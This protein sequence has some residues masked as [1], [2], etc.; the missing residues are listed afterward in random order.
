MST[1]LNL[2]DQNADTLQ[3]MALLGKYLWLTFG[4]INFCFW[5]LCIIWLTAFVKDPEVGEPLLEAITTYK[6][7]K[8]VWNFVSKDDQ[9]ERL[10]NETIVNIAA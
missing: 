3:Q 8:A 1:L 6:V 7:G 9:I 2:L 5:H 4:T 10:R